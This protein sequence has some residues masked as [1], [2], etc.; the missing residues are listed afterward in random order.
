M[1]VR[2]FQNSIFSW[3]ANGVHS[4]HQ[5]RL[6][7]SEINAV[8]TC[9]MDVFLTMFVCCICFCSCSCCSCSCDNMWQPRSM[10]QKNWDFWMLYRVLKLPERK[11]LPKHNTFRNPVP[12]LWWIDVNTSQNGRWSQTRSLEAIASWH[13]KTTWRK[14]RK[15]VHLHSCCGGFFCFLHS[16]WGWY[17][18]YCFL[19]VGVVGSGEP[20][21]PCS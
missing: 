21:G 8:E 7:Q 17:V 3:M 20:N 13:R 2:S 4:T 10:E 9:I 16:R 11:D 14:R 1:T 6:R 15:T 18:F 12:V 19:M 5:P